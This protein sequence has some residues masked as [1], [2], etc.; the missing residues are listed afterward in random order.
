MRDAG[1]KQ[2]VV[3]RVDGEIIPAA[4]P[5]GMKYPGDP[6][7]PGC[8]LSVSAGGRKEAGGKNGKNQ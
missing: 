2:A 8:G 4:I 5:A 7:L 6:I 3:G 1:N